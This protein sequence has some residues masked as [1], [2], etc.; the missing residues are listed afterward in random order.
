MESHCVRF[1]EHVPSPITHLAVTPPFA[2]RPMVAVARDNGDIEIRLP[3]QAWFLERVIMGGQNRSISALAWGHQSVLTDPD[4]YDDDQERQFVLKR[5]TSKPP[6]LFSASLNGFITEWDMQQLSP[7]KSV[8]ATGGGV[9][10]LAVNPAGTLLAAGCEDG[11]IRLYDIADDDWTL[12]RTFN[13]QLG[14]VLCLAWHPSGDYLVSGSDK[15]TLRKWDVKTGTTLDRATLDRIDRHPTVIWA[16]RVLPDGTVVTGSSLGRVEW[17]DWTT[18]TLL[19]SVH[20]HESDVLALDVMRDGSAIFSSSIDRQ[21]VQ[22][23]QTEA[24]SHLSWV[25][26]HR[27]RYHANDVKAVAVVEV[28]GVRALCS[29]GI[30]AEFTVIDLALGFKTC[31]QRRLDEFQT[32]RIAVCPSRHWLLARFEHTLRLFKLGRTAATNPAE[33]AGKK[34]LSQL[35]VAHRPLTLAEVRLNAA[36]NIEH[37]VLSNDGS[38]LAVAHMDAVKLWRVHADSEADVHDPAVEEN[39]AMRRVK[40]PA[41][42]PRLRHL[43]VATITSPL[44]NVADDGW[45]LVGVAKDNSVHVWQ[46]SDAEPPRHVAALDHHGRDFITHLAI[47]RDARYLATA[48]AAGRAFVVDL[49]T[50]VTLSTSSSST[51]A[52]LDATRFEKKLLPA[53]PNAITSLSLTTPM[54]AHGHPHALLVITLANRHFHIFE[55]PTWAPHAWP[56]KNLQRLGHDVTD[57][58]DYFRGAYALPKSRLLLWTSNWFLAVDL[59]RDLDAN[60]KRKSV[61]TETGADADAVEV[62]DGGQSKGDVVAPSRNLGIEK[63]GYGLLSRYQRLMHVEVLSETE[64]VVVERPWMDVAAALPGAFTRKKYGM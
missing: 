22:Y 13:K 58:Q 47:S 5:V 20:A 33:L 43:A 51:A 18:M 10:S 31:P 64:M 37:A 19:R 35:E 50:A 46:L 49:S 26:A 59:L 2:P 56:R 14:R 15:S 44:P 62:E 36:R 53:Y 25:L 63:R 7:K 29:G 17:W 23:R 21:V 57:R 48:D 32:S 40:L 34:F 12:L 16:V 52:P 55:A 3:N 54:P 11:C 41:A 28:R 1:V 9:W 30:D 45:L 60:K 24:G 39:V 61:S 8:D 38:W 4:F 6:R 27:R 42:I